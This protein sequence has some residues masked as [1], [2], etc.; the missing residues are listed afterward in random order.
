MSDL[1][2]LTPMLTRPKSKLEEQR[3][4]KR[5]SKSKM[6]WWKHR[7]T[8]LNVPSTKWKRFRRLMI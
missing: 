2:S 1:T 5:G 6:S 3:M 8:E 4:P 7:R